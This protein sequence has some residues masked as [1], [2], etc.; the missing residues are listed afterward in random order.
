[1]FW[2]SSR[3]FLPSISLVGLGLSCYS[4]YVE[5]Q[6]ETDNDYVALCDITPRISCTK[7]FK[8]T[9]A[10]GFGIIDKLVGVDHWL[11]QPNPVYGTAFY[12]IIFVFGLLNLAVVRKL[13][14]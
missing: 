6:L 5:L 4:L 12:A 2:C 11:N 13:Q 3:L 7:V 8:T 10:K 9:Y 14:V 1:M